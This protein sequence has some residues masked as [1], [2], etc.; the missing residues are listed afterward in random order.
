MEGGRKIKNL[1]PIEIRTRVAGISAIRIRSDNRYTTAPHC[2]AEA[3]V[4]SPFRRSSL[5]PKECTDK[6]QFNGFFC[7]E[8][9][10]RSVSTSEAKLITVEIDGNEWIKAKRWQGSDK[11]RSIRFIIRCDVVE[12]KMKGKDGVSFG[13]NL[14]LE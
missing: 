5:H 12:R 11:V 13:Y 14:C 8:F 6:L 7:L 4:S 2:S 3:L 10:T 1:G 9:L